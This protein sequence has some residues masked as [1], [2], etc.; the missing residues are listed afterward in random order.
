[1][2]LLGALGMWL[3]AR[4]FPATPLEIPYRPALCSALVISAGVLDLAALLAF[5]RAKTTAS[6]LR[7][8]A[9]SVLVVSGLYRHSRNPMYC[10]LLLM[11]GA[12]ACYLAQALPFLVLPVFVLAMNRFQIIPEERILA[13][14]FGASYAVY[15]K[16]VRRWI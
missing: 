12:W 3:I 6:P 13:A 15:L 8:E 9:S 11:L 14:R 2:T 16:T 10:G 1:M 7:P 4:Y 5:H